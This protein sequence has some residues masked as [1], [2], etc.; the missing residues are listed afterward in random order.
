M[1]I[2]IVGDIHA[3][4]TH[5]MYL[6]FC[7]DLFQR[8]RVDRVHFAGDIVDLHSLSFWEHDP[9]GLSPET[10]AENALEEVDRWHRT[11]DGTV[12]IGN[13]DERHYRTARRAGM[14]DR[15]LKSYA[16]VWK[17]PRW[18]WGLSFCFD[19]VNYSHGTGSSG[20]WGAITLA[21]KKRKS[22]V[23]GH[24]HAHGGVQS[25]ASDDDIIFGL[26]VGCGID[27]RAYA[28][29][30]GRTHVD[31]PSLGAGIVIDGYE[32]SF[33]PMPIGR[34]EKYHRSR[35]GKRAARP[36]KFLLPLRRKVKP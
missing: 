21:I 3:P 17:T 36:K 6:R 29:A 24:I 27:C 19:G 26:N 15:Y 10:E 9:A 11:F 8:F 28:F 23:I 7:V 14:P 1:R 30:Y 34:G 20:R 12:S 22:C 32:A 13:H 33:H 16:E 25:H 2:G 31:R 18:K 4:F 35:A 5:P